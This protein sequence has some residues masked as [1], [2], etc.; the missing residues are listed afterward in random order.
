[1]NHGNSQPS[2][3]LVVIT[4]NPYIGGLKWFKPIIF[5][6]FGF[7]GSKGILDGWLLGG[8]KPLNQGSIHQPESARPNRWLDHSLNEMQGPFHD[9]V[10]KQTNPAMFFFWRGSWG[11]VR[12]NLGWKKVYP[13]MKIKEK[14]YSKTATLI[15]F[16]FLKATLVVYRIPCKVFISWTGLFICFTNSWYTLS[17]LPSTHNFITRKHCCISKRYEGN[18]QAL[19]FKMD[20]GLRKKTASYLVATKSVLEWFSWEL[21]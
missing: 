9:H 17:E 6:G 16:T 1:M 20:H 7:G 11:I 8:L 12:F 13:Y 5:H 21:G 2:V 14:S 4:N 10:K 3:L 18:C 15:P 19:A